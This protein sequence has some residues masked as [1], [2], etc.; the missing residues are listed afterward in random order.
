MDSSWDIWDKTNADN[1]LDELIRL[2]HE[3]D[4][5]LPLIE[6]LGVSGADYAAWVEGRLSAEALLSRGKYG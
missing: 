6:F 2:W 5:E 3:G 4:S 1:K